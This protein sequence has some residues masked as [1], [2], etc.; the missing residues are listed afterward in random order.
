MSE[1]VAVELGYV[2]G[3]GEMGGEIGSSKEFGEGMCRGD[4]GCSFYGGHDG[5]VETKV[6]IVTLYQGHL[7]C[8]QR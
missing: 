2:D 7:R 6:G 1:D 5:G 3:G 4:G 8:R